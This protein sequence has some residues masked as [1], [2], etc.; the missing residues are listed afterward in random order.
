MT[1]RILLC[2]ALLATAAANA[3][4]NMSLLGDIDYQ[5]THNSNLSNIW[6]YVDDLG[7]EYALIGVNGDP[8]QTNTGG[9][10]VVDV[11]DPAVPVEVAFFN[12]ANSDWREI[13]TYGDYAYVTTEASAGL[14]SAIHSL[15]PKG[16]CHLLTV[17]GGIGGTS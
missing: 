10:A 5:S 4:V 12:G 13:K 11:T 7:N 6:G 9:L 1:A 3:Q 17:S 2:S 14:S 16:R 8:N 15:C